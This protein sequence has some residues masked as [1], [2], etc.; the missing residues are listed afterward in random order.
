MNNQKNNLKKCAN[1]INIDDGPY[2]LNYT[3]LFNKEKSIDLSQ[4]NISTEH[5][6]WDISTL[7]YY[8]L[9]KIHQHQ[10][11]ITL[12]QLELKNKE[13][14]IKELSFKNNRQE[15]PYERI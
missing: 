3:N 7:I 6:V 2:K 4:I 14:I 15:K 8:I 12:L 1:D 9:S 13:K 11:Q 5:T 10:N